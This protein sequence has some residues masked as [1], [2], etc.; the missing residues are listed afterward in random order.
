MPSPFPGMDP[1]LE[2][3]DWQS[4][5]T[6]LIAEFGRQLTPKLLPKYVTLVG[7]REVLTIRGPDGEPADAT[8]YADVAI[9]K[10][11]AAV[12]ADEGELTGGVAVAA[13]AR[14]RTVIG[15]PAAERFLE[16]RDA[17]DRRLVTL[18]EVLSPTN[19]RGNGHLAY[20]DKRNHV[21]RSDTHLIEVDLHHAGHRVPMRDT[22]PPAPYYALVSRADDRPM[23]EVWPI[24]LDARLPEIP[25]PLAAPDAD[26]RLDLQRALD[27]VYDDLGYR[28]VLD[29]SEAPAVRLNQRALAWVRGRLDA[30]GLP[31]WK[32][33][34]ARSE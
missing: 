23:T 28:V 10:P 6:V 4:F 1:Y 24:P 2:G 5:H 31:P 27:S 32:A 14:V 19:K 26:V 21:L 13:P 11:A 9:A 3:P 16:I 18:I 8:M 7:Q 15:Q 20:V 25:V 33:S 34:S 30:A 17:K 22:L 29:Y 12:A